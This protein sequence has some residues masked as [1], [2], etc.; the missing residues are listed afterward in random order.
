MVAL[1]VQG[2]S[3]RR[4]FVLLWSARDAL[5]VEVRALIDHLGSLA[6]KRWL[7]PS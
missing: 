4:R 3:F 6:H 2:L 5:G 1:R 7:S